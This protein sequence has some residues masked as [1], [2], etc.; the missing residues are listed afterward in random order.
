MLRDAHFNLVRQHTAPRPQVWCEVAD[1]VGMLIKP[2]MT[3][4]AAWAPPLDLTQ[5]VGANFDYPGWEETMA[6]FMAE[7]VKAYR[8]HPS[9]VLW[10]LTNETF[11]SIDPTGAGR[12]RFRRLADRLREMDLTR[13]IDTESEADPPGRA[14]RFDV[15]NH[16]WYARVAPPEVDPFYV[17]NVQGWPE[18]YQRPLILGEC[19]VAQTHTDYYRRDV[20]AEER[21]RV[22]LREAEWVRTTVP[23]LLKWD[24]AGICPHQGFL[25]TWDCVN[26]G[27]WGPEE[28][29]PIPIPWPALSGPGAKPPE[30]THLAAQSINWFD[31]SHPVYRPTVVH[32]ALQETWRPM[33]PLHR[34]TAPELLVEVIAEGQPLSGA[35]I[36]AIPLDG[37]AT[38]PL[39]VWADEEGK[40]WFVLPE[41]GRYEMRVLGHQETQVVRAR[42]TW[43]GRRA[44]FSP[45][46]V[47]FRLNLRPRVSFPLPGFRALTVGPAPP[48]LLQKHR[49]PFAISL[50]LLLLAGRP[51]PA[52]AQQAPSV[53]LLRQG[54]WQV[55]EARTEQR[56]GGVALTANGTACASITLEGVDLR[57]FPELVFTVADVTPGRR[58]NLVTEVPEGR[59]GRILCLDT[60]FPARHRLPLAETFLTNRLEKVEI[61]M[62][63]GGEPGEMGVTMVRIGVDW[64][65]FTPTG[66]PKTRDVLSRV[67]QYLKERDIEPLL[68]PWGIP[69]GA[70]GKPVAS[71]EWITAYAQ[72]CVDYLVYLRDTMHVPIRF[73]E[74]TNEPHGQPGVFTQAVL[75]ELAREFLSCCRAAQLE[76]SLVG[77]DN[78][79]LKWAIPWHEA[80]NREADVIGAKGGIGLPSLVDWEAS[81]VQYTGSVIRQLVGWDIPMFYTEF[82]TW[83]YTDT[84]EYVQPGVYGQDRWEQGLDMAQLGV[85]YLNSGLSVVLFW[86]LY[87]VRRTQAEAGFYKYGAIA[88]KTEGWRK[89]PKY[90]LMKCVFGGVPRGAYVARTEVTGGP[91]A[92]ALYW[93]SGLHVG[94]INPYNFDQV[95]RVQIPRAEWGPTAHVFT[96]R[97]TQV[98]SESTV[99]VEN[100]VATVA[101]PARGGVGVT[102]RRVQRDRKGRALGPNLAY[103]RDYTFAPPFD[104]VGATNESYPDSGGT[105]L[106]DG[107]L[108]ETFFDGKSVGWAEGTTQI[109]VDLGETMAV[110]RVGVWLEVGGYAAVRPPEQIRVQVSE[111]SKVWRTTGETEIPDVTLNQNVVQRYELPVGAMGRFVRLGLKNRNWTMVS[112]VEVLRGTENVAARKP[113][114]TEPDRAVFLE[115]QPGPMILT[116]GL[117]A[118]ANRPHRRSAVFLEA[119]PRPVVVD[120]GSQKMV[121]TVVIRCARLKDLGLV[122]PEAAV[123]SLSSDGTTWIT[124]G[125]AKPAVDDAPGWVS[126]EGNY[127]PSLAQYVRVALHGSGVAVDEIE[128]YGP[129]D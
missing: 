12:R 4:F 40:A 33:P 47:E 83:A 30:L 92:A 31:P 7:W 121:Q 60:P 112:E 86:E 115:P 1:E 123:V 70:E 15:A 125:E 10:S 80:L 62:W 96:T 63:M 103:R 9:V 34:Y 43:I 61:K 48:R 120:L 50:T 102:F 27:V 25:L 104:R 91:R 78:I 67:F 22:W 85:E 99:T 75:G 42:R 124:A 59:P 65:D 6:A 53:D 114:V 73:F 71:H 76:I 41:E 20:S 36:F 105:E 118:S 49:K 106:T 89:R 108:S 116:D 77:P 79:D 109:T 11:G 122:L 81:M 38:H 66:G 35:S 52:P 101:L 95:V 46:R 19:G 39:G 128:V 37:Q 68:V 28:P 69:A 54:Q 55:Y 17:E 14:D 98:A 58:Y 2:E 51:L 18:R 5:G 16:H 26:G 74:L 127:E 45:A 107:V 110:D 57:V 29:E 23:R 119:R 126:I 88:Y 100:N 44:G 56:Q 24:V 97:P 21:Y 94:I 111:D 93:P 82:N 84:K 3:G 8:N 87:D 72:S 13:P 90:H 113:Y 32:Q 117:H 129:A 64:H